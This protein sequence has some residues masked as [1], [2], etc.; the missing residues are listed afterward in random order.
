MR[1]RDF[2]ALVLL[3]C[4]ALVQGH[5]RPEM[6]S[7][8]VSEAHPVDGGEWSSS[9]R[10]TASPWD[11]GSGKDARECVEH[12]V[13][14]DNR[15]PQTLECVASFSTQSGSTPTLD[16]AEVPALVLPRTG[17]EIRGPIATTE[18]NVALSHLE[19][20]ARAPYKR[21]KVAPG[22]K[23]QMFGKPL[24]EFYPAAALTQ[25]LEGPV[26]IGF[27]L[28]QRNGPATEIAIVDS[29]LVYSLDE[30]AKRFV[31]GQRFSTNCPGTRY[32]LRMRFTLRDRY[33]A[34]PTR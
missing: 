22:C 34:Q 10:R 8:S 31:A 15:S 17:H 18:T 9:I 30:A 27:L 26:A 32:D 25:A 29:S 13:V 19:C 4:A 33:L 6:L 20:H 14:I 28:P 5:E 24:E 11:C 7:V 1:S 3:L 21:L 12:S 23:F 16:G 2:S